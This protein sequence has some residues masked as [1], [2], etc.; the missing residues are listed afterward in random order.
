MMLKWFF[1]LLLLITGS[2]LI[3]STFE[4]FS[5]LDSL[6]KNL[7]GIGCY[8]GAIVIGRRHFQQGS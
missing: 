3:A 8:V 4:D 6:F 7:I 1:V 2:V 5:H